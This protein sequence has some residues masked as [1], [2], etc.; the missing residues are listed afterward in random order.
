M[1]S[2]FIYIYIDDYR[3]KSVHDSMI[4]YHLKSI[5]INIVC[6]DNMYDMALH[7]ISCFVLLDHI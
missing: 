7:E 6:Y 4:L 1:S 3:S 2:G 5:A